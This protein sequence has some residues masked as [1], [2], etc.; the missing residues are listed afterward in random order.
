MSRAAALGLAVALAGFAPDAARAG[1]YQTIYDDGE[2]RHWQPRYAEGVRWNYENVVLRRL[3]PEERRALAGVE[4]IFPLRDAKHDPFAYNADWPRVT[5]STLSL[6]FFDDLSVAIAWLWR[7]GYSLETA[8]EYVATLKYRRAADFGRRLPKPF[9][10]IRVPKDVLA[11][12]AVDDLAQKIFK[13][14]VVFILAHELGHIVHGHPGYGP[15]VSRAEARA[16]EAEA[17]AFALEVMRRIGAMPAGMA[18]F[19]Q[20]MAYGGPNRGDF[21]DDDA[22]DR[23]LA[24]A[25]HPV[26]EDRMRAIAAAL[27][28]SPD[29]FAQEFKDPVVGRQNT[30]YIAD[31]LDT[32]ADFLADRD[33]QRLISQRARRATLASLAPRRPGEQIGQEPSQMPEPAAA[34]PFEGTYDGTFTYGGRNIDIRVTMKRNDERVTGQY[35]YGGGPGRIDGLVVGD[36]LVFHWQEGN[37]SGRGAFAT[38]AA[39]AAF[40]GT[41]GYGENEAGGGTWTG[42]RK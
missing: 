23:A 13:S 27:K 39:G 34:P 37:T 32:V 20:A 21:R 22:Y 12:K 28:A 29:D 15:D 18:F 6:K 42:R 36:R 24:G 14:A 4:L 7:N 5:L 40:A 16:N 30:L 41:W 8:Y 1:D 38:Q 2:L 10:A 25:T 35:D 17:D 33:L 3:T 31:Q 19:F 11:D 9:E 26:T